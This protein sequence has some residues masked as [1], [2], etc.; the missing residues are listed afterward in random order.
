MIVAGIDPSLTSAGVA[1]LAHGG[2][3]HIGHYGFGAR[4]TGHSGKSYQSRS[5]RIRKQVRDVT[6]AALNI[7][8]PVENSRP[9][10]A[11]IEEHPYSVGAHG[12]EMD[13][14]AIWHGI[15][16]QLDAAGIPIVVVH[17]SRLKSWVIGG[18]ATKQDV[19]DTVEAWYN[20]AVSCDDEADAI[21]LASIGAA[22]AH[23]PLPFELKPRHHNTIGTLTWPNT[24]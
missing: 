12:S 10:L 3:D 9:D 7:H 18:R 24:A 11:I 13:R 8:C 21:A 1:I 16:G 20:T 6:A 22:W 4:G 19:I 5:R 23:D 14:I 15:Y 2:L 17:P